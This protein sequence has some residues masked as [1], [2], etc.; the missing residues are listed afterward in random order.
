MIPWAP[1]PLGAAGLAAYVGRA[2]EAVEE[3]EAWGLGKGFRYLV[4]DKGRGTMGR[5]E[6]VE[7]VRWCAGEGYVFELGFDGME[8]KGT[9][10]LW[11]LEEAVGYLGR[12]YARVREGRGRGGW[13]L[14]VCGICVLVIL[15]W[16][17]V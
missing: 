5:E 12:V 8:G 9:R 13:L 14:L 3:E 16:V 4:Q 11:Q 2:R 1:L 17:W 7:G 6:F 15:V 10:S